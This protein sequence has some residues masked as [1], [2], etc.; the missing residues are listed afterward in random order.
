MRFLDGPRSPRQNRAMKADG[1][2]ANDDEQLATRLAQARDSKARLRDARHAC[3]LLYRRHARLLLA[4]LAA[5]VERAELEDV[6]HT[7]WLRV[8]ENAPGSFRGGSFRGWLHQIARNYLIDI[9][10]RRRTEMR[11]ATDELPDA[12]AADGPLEALIDRERRQ[13]LQ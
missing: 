3:E 12:R 7:I 11:D 2:P 6:H 1:D 5:R 10:R 13:S 8:W 4:Y 9:S